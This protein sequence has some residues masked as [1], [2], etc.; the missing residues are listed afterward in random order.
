M[1][2]FAGRAGS[3]EEVEAKQACAGPAEAAA[4]GGMTEVLDV[5]AAVLESYGRTSFDLPER[6]ADELFGLCETWARHVRIASPPP[7]LKGTSERRH[8]ADLQAFFGGARREEASY[9]KHEF[10]AFREALIEINVRLQAGLHAT[11]SEDGSLR[12]AID[13]LRGAADAPAVS[14]DALRR[15]ISRTTALVEEALDARAERDAKTM[16]DLSAQLDRAKTEVADA[17]RDAETDG[18]TGVFNRG[19][20]DRQLQA[21]MSF[22]AVSEDSFVLLLLDID[23]FKIINDSLG[24]LAGDAVLK[25]VA[26]TLLRTVMRKGDTIARFGGDEFAVLL[27][28]CDARAAASVTKRIQSRLL[29][30][31]EGPPIT[32]SIGMATFRGWADKGLS[33]DDLLAAADQALY[34]AK[35]AGRNCV[36]AAPSALVD[37]A[38]RAAVAGR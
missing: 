36:R 37:A 25:R 38:P 29:E 23:R 31:V 19:A 1:G 5:L 17:R 28:D 15:E 14:L 16:R 30:T 8:W 22:C 3:D 21:A 20:F 26:D 10:S 2:W 35:S 11:Q 4:A 33:A 34:A 32:A 9:V 12:H 6:S 18:L 27:H 13:G 7:G 24:H